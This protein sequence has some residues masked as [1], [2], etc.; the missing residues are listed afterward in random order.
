VASHF[1]QALR[2][3]SLEAAWFM[4]LMQHA[5]GHTVACSAIAS[6]FPPPLLLVD[7][8]PATHPSVTPGRPL[9]TH[10]AL[11]TAPWRLAMA[12]DGL[13]QRLGS[14]N[15][16]RGVAALRGW[17]TGPARD[18][19]PAMFLHDSE[20]PADDELFAELSWEGWDKVVQLS[21]DDH[22]ERHRVLSRVEAFVGQ[23]TGDG[24]KGSAAASAVAEAVDNAAVH[25]YG[26]S[27]PI[28]V[29][30]RHEGHRVRVE[31][32]DSGKANQIASGDGRKLM[33]HYASAVDFWYG[34]SGGTVVSL[35]FDVEKVNEET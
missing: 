18:Q 25:G 35:A 31:I 34:A 14:G 5:Q 10:R 6:G 17:L 9:D 19:D 26:G 32:E 11:L 33:D 21:T 20:E 13:L 23:G 27:G 12:S 22:R 16:R 8:P 1:Q 24:A 3:A 30:L 29:S 15:E 4:A 28:Q 2:A 7:A